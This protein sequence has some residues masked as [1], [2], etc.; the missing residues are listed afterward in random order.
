MECWAGSVLVWGEQ[1]RSQD[2]SS[3][4]LSVF[5][6]YHGAITHDGTLCSSY[7]LV[8]LRDV[9]DSA[10]PRPKLLL[11][12]AELSTQS[13]VRRALVKVILV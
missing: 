12:V 7:P 2:L 6:I 10:L 9:L 3:K 11:S 4:A 1:G 13:C 5:Q 8:D